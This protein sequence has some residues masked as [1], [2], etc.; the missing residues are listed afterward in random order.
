MSWHTRGKPLRA[1]VQYRE[2]LCTRGRDCKRIPKSRQLAA[3]CNIFP[4]IRSAERHA[5]FALYGTVHAYTLDKR[6]ITQRHT[7][8]VLCS[9]RGHRRELKRWPITST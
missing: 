2:F 9:Q 1:S 5:R 6:A 8:L 3:E 7:A 4:E